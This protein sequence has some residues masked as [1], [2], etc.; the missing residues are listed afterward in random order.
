MYMD[1]A[2]RKLA[3]INGYEDS[4]E[5]CDNWGIPKVSLFNIFYRNRGEDKVEQLFLPKVLM[6]SKDE[7][8][9]KVAEFIRNH[10]PSKK[11]PYSTI[12]VWDM[13]R[14][15]EEIVRQKSDFVFEN[16][17]WLVTIEREKVPQKQA[18]GSVIYVQ[19][20]QEKWD[21]RI[22]PKKNISE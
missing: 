18:D 13:G 5:L 3:E 9:S 22:Y 21:M 1:Q 16:D 2:K 4:Q 10:V 20:E 19:T 8:G 6:D 12:D 7:L 17:S 14:S 15:A 11:M